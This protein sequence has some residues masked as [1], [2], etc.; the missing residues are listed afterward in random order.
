MP[1]HHKGHK[2][3]G[4]RIIPR[5][6]LRHLVGRGMGSVLL[7]KGGAGPGSSYS[8]LEQYEQITGNRIPNSMGSGLAS[9]L[10]AGMARGLGAG[11]TDKLSKLVVKPLK[12]KAKN[13]HFDF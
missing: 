9:G 2:V 8:S 7:N 1:R 11:I 13:I 4:G 3:V 12:A 6:H 5:T 10:G